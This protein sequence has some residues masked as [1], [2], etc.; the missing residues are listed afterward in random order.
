MHHL[1]AE[2]PGPERD[3]SRSTVT[4]GLRNGYL[5]SL[6][7]LIQISLLNDDVLSNDEPV[8]SHLTEM[9]KHPG[10]VLFKIDKDDHDRQVPACL[11]QTRGMYVGCAR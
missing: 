3:T 10:N 5:K 11:Y 2:T 6:D 7:P 1:R 9:G 4:A 8:R